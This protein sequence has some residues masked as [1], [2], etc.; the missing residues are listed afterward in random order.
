MQEENRI[1]KRQCQATSPNEIESS[2][3]QDREEKRR[4]R[5]EVGAGSTFE[6]LKF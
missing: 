3:R 5:G 2:F 1:W 4:E 6:R